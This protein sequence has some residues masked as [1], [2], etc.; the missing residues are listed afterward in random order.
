[1]K[2]GNRYEG[3]V[4]KINFPNKAVVVT[5][6]GE[7]ATVK[8]ALVGQKIAFSAKKVRKGK[9][10]GRLLE[11]LE[12]SPDELDVP[13][14]PH[15]S[16][17]GGCA[18]QSLPYEKQLALK[19]K[20]V[21]ELLDVV[22]EPDSYEFQGVK[23]SP[24]QFG[25]RNKMEYSFGDAEKDGPL[26]LGMH[27]RGSFHD[28]VTVDQC[29]IVDADYN[30]I[31][32]CTQEFF[33]KRDVAF[34]HKMRHTGYLRHLLVRRGE[35]TGEILIDLVTTTQSFS[36]KVIQQQIVPQSM[37]EEEQKEEEKMLQEYAESLKNLPLQGKIAGILH[38]KNDSVADVVKDEGTDI[39]YGKDYFYEELLGLKFKIST[40]SFFQ[41]NSLGAELLYQTAREFIGDALQKEGGSVVYD[42]YSGTGTI[43]QMLAPVAK[44]VIGVEIVEEAVEAAKE[45]AKENELENCD[46]LAGDVMKVLDTIEEKPDFIVLDPPRDGI[47]P[48]AL[49]RIIRYG[50]DRMV[51]ISC[52]PT[53]LQRDLV[54]LQERGYQVEKVACVDM[55]PATVHVE[56]VCLLTRKN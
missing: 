34:F 30:Q 46:F 51:Y 25:Y 5:D 49:D 12:K 11:V 3:V 38:T 7:R 33:R 44:K 10:E 39:L 28:I 24:K 42:L 52:K 1:M 53:S 41:T 20:Q 21:K 6:E 40:F 14:C 35:K 32:A 9:A 17:C 8:N 45:N 26:T 27:K 16:E 15:F 31:L 22:V 23:P 18:Y 19:E 54:V 56:T 4:E 36:K 29:K 50:V 13:N 2:K 48:K 47:H 43:A 55:F 37:T